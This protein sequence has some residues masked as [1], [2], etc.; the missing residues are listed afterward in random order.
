MVVESLN[1]AWACIRVRAPEMEY[2]QY[3]THLP[4]ESFGCLEIGLTA[5]GQR[6]RLRLVRWDWLPRLPHAH[7]EGVILSEFRRWTCAW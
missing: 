7:T 2:E 3:V 1:N 6:F 4:V 5:Y